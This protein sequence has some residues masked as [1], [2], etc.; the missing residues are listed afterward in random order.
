MGDEKQIIESLLFSAGRP[1]TIKEIRDVTGLTPQ[2]IRAVL[3]KLIREYAEKDTAM[4]IVKAGKKYV[5]QVKPMYS[6]ESIAEPELDDDILKTL[7]LIA[8][9]Q[10]LKQ[11]NL[12][13]MIGPKIYEHVDKLVE[14]KLVHSKKHG[15]TEIL[16]LTSYFPEY[17][18]ISTSNP[19]EIKQFLMNKMVEEI[20]K[21]GDSLND[22]MV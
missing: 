20:K 22:E 16:T 14:M 13:R 5:M 8:F 18:G 9:H 19:E 12:R 1:L 6:K 15:T 4:E 2:K 17:F 3:Q 7:A 21:D 10:P 11:S